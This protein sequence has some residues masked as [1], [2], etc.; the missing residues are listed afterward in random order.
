MFNPFAHQMV[1]QNCTK[2]PLRAFFDHEKDTKKACFLTEKVPF[3]S[4]K[5]STFLGYFLDFCDCYLL[6]C[7]L[8]G[9][10]PGFL[11]KKN[12]NLRSLTVDGEVREAKA[13]A[14]PGWC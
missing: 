14:N 3:C 4:L 12:G 10:G 7:F 2:F 5:T 8:E 13:K 6:S 9:A 1:I 11:A